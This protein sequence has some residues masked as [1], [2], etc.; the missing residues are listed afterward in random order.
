VSLASG[1]ISTATVASQV[2]VTS[3]GT[4]TYGVKRA[5][6]CRVEATSRLL[7]RP[8]GEEAVSSHVLY[9]DQAVALTDRLW[10]PGVSAATDDGARSPIAISVTTDKTGSRAL[11]KVEL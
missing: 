4:P 2:S 11:Y 9:T 5:L 7:R 6:R 1:F 10:L 3:Y 8:N